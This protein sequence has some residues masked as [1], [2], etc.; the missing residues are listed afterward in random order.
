MASQSYGVHT[1]P[2]KS[3]PVVFCEDDHLI[4]IAEN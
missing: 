3:A 2:D 4:V 1:N